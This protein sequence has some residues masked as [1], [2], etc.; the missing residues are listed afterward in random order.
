MNKQT[1]ISEKKNNIKE[2]TSDKI[3]RIKCKQCVQSLHQITKSF[4]ILCQQ[5]FPTNFCVNKCKYVKI[6]ENSNYRFRSPMASW[7][8]TAL[9]VVVGFILFQSHFPQFSMVFSDEAFMKMYI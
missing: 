6:S 3:E 7:G 1:K 4:N 2:R 5:R 9:S 8:I